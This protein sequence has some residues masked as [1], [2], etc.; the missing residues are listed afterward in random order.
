MPIID[1]DDYEKQQAI[2]ML[3]SELAAGDQSAKEQGYVTIDELKEYLSE[4]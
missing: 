3:K 1:I 4:I 2:D